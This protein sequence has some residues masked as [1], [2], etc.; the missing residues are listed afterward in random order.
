MFNVL[1][2]NHITLASRLHS[3]KGTMERFF[4]LALVRGCATAHP[5]PDLH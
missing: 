4:A 2:F 3:P 5:E 1:D